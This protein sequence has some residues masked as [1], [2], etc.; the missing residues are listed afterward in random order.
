VET[1]TAQDLTA[2]L[3][4]YMDLMNF[5][6]RA[7]Y[8][9]DYEQHMQTLREAGRPVREVAW[10]ADHGLPPAYL[11]FRKADQESRNRFLTADT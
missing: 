6:M 10:P 11:R 3:Q 2:F 1:E 4:P 7:I 9:L 8:G 5:D